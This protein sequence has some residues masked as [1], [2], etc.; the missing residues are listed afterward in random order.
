MDSQWMYGAALLGAAAL[1][2]LGRHRRGRGPGARET[3][4]ERALAQAG[5]LTELV[6]AL[7]QHR[8]MSGAWLAGDASFGARL[9]ERQAGIERLFAQVL[10]AAAAEDAEAFPC[11]ISQDVLGLRFR[12]REL[13]QELAVLSA[14]ESF[15]RHSRMVAILLEWLSALGEARIAPAGGAYEPQAVRRLL[16]QL[17]ALAECL[18]QARALSSA[19]AARGRCAPVARVRL[20]FLVARATQLV[21]RSA[22]GG[23]GEAAWRAATAFLTLLREQVLG[24]PQV[25]TDAATC[26]RL[27]SV[28]VDAVYA[29][30]A[31]ERAALG[32]GRYAHAF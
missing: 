24:S 11:F 25:G 22:S 23:Q 9:G 8:G 13:V 18:G 3:Q 16:G 15:R 6:A 1:W 29:W 19:V 21:E 28:A 14:E 7:Q 12:W 26:F 27:G 2:M 10:E 31:E 30:I 17:P 20:S 4:A 32:A 5:Q